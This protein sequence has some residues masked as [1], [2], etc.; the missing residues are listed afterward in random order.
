MTFRPDKL[1]VKTQEALQRAHFMAQE[2]SHQQL[3]PLHLLKSLLEEEQGV[4]RALIDKIGAEFSQ[5]HDMVESELNR[6]PKVTGSGVQVGMSPET[7]NVLNASQQIADGMQDQYVSTEHL[8]LALAKT[9]SAAQRLLQLNAI[10]EDD[11][12]SALKSVR[13]GQ[14]VTDQS[15]EEKYQSLEKYGKDLV[16]LARQGKI[17][18]VIGRNAEIRRVIQVLSR[19][20]K[21][22]PVLIGEPGVGKTAIVEGIAH[23]IVL[24][25]VPQNLKDNGYY[26]LGIGKIYH[27]PDGSFTDAEHSW[28]HWIDAG[29]GTN[30]PVNFAEYYIPGSVFK[31]GANENSVTSHW[32]Y[33]NSNLIAKLIEGDTVSR[34]GNDYALPQNQPFF[35]ACGI[36]RPHHPIFAPQEMVDLFDPADMTGINE[37][38]LQLVTD[39]RNDLSNQGLSHA[40]Q[41]HFG[42]LRPWKFEAITGP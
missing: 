15:P 5:L 17:D 4:V 9:D 1:T 37:D 19:R 38:Y 29:I 10:E 3:R 42:Y 8:L 33:W 18:P 30:G 35:L 31:F 2:M 25:D 41:G 12:L 6:L 13:G 16:E 26:S 36:Y 27:H 40:P 11:I 24:G 23:R 20:R 21:N 32:D 39:D 14:T 28:T 34:N 7:M 22:N